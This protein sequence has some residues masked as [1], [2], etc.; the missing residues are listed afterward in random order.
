[1]P[2]IR[3]GGRFRGSEPSRG[4]DD[5]ALGNFTLTLV[6]TLDT[7]ALIDEEE[8]EKATKLV[9]DNV[10]FDTDVVVSVFETNIR[11]VREIRGKGST[12]WELGL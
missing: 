11:F 3:P 12:V 10:Q 1:M 9:I 7:L 5:D 4:N 6:D 8:F 2:G